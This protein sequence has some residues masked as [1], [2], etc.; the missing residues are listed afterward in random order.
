MVDTPL[1]TTNAQE[2]GKVNALLVHT[3]AVDPGHHSSFR[4]CTHKEKSLKCV[5]QSAHEKA[6]ILE[7]S[8]DMC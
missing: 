5:L 2:I 3:I 6:L 8:L 7:G 4:V 1:I